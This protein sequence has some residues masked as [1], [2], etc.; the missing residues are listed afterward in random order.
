MTSFKY[1]LF[2]AFVEN[3]TYAQQIGGNCIQYYNLKKCVG[4]K[5]NQFAVV[6]GDQGF[7]TVA[8]GNLQCAE[9]NSVSTASPTAA[10]TS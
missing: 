9:F 8:L 3:T 6:P 1:T 7:G 2:Y 5:G 10:P 4:Q